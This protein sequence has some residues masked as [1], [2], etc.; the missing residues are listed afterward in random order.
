MKVSKKHGAFI[1]N[2]G[3]GTLDDLKKLIKFIKTTV[4]D[5]FAIELEEEVFYVK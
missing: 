5:K 2:T 1:I 3:K 4:K